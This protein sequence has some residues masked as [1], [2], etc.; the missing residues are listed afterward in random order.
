MSGSNGI[1]QASDVLVDERPRL[2]VN[3]GYR[4]K[5]RRI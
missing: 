5:E 2:L 3:I 1:D 4:E